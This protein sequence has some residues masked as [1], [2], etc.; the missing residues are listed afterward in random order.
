MFFPLLHRL[1]GNTELCAV[2]R[3]F[4]SMAIPTTGSH[5]MAE[6]LPNATLSIY[7]GAGHGAIFQK[8]ELFASQAIAFYLADR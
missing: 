2:G 7:E 5:D 8:A 4:V 1:Q 6:R 3:L